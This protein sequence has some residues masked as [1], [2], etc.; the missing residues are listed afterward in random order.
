MKLNFL[1][2]LCFGIFLFTSCKNDDSNP[3]PN[4]PNLPNPEGLIS[5]QEATAMEEAYKLE[6]YNI[7]NDVKL[8]NYPGF[9]GA[10]R[11]VWFDLDE[12]KQYIAYVERHA[13]ENG[14]NGNLGLRVYMGAKVQNNSIS[15]NPEP[16]QTVFF[17]PTIKQPNNDIDQNILSAE[18]LNLGGAGVP[19]SVDSNV[20]IG[21]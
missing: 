6:F 15:G 19:D 17:V 1:A 14:Y 18:R 5:V 3:N 10:G 7:L 13:A 4:I 8:N 12:V 11:Y 9:E 2:I 16:R 20:G 21:N